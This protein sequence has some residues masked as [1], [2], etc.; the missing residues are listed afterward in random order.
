MVE[1]KLKELSYGNSPDNNVGW[2][3]WT[4]GVRHRIPWGGLASSW[5]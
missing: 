5:L 2:I 3:D 1:C 4:G